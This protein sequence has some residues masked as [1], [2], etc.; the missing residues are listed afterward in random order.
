M[1]GEQCVYWDG[2]TGGFNCKARDVGKKGR[3][4]LRSFLAQSSLPCPSG[5]LAV[6]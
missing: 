2:T 6:R 5:F 1:K 3:D 4:A